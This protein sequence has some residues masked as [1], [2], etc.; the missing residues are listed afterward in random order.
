ME[1]YKVK[2]EI[3]IPAKFAKAFEVKKGQLMAI[4]D[5]EGGQIGDF[6]AFNQENHN[7]KFSPSHTRLKLLSLKIK[8]GDM[9][10]LIEVTK[11][12]EKKTGRRLLVRVTHIQRGSVYGIPSEYMIL[13]IELLY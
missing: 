12:D 6:I 4:I 8:V 2:T 3:L 10:E 1:G 13:S 9:L 7:E 11:E 5:V